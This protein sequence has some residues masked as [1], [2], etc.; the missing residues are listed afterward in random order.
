MA[1]PKGHT[2]SD[3]GEAGVIALFSPPGGAIGEKVVVPNGDDAAAFFT[4]PRYVS[5][6]TTDTLVEHVHFELGH[7]P[8]IRVGRKLM[9]V[10]LSDIAAMG[11]TPRYALL[12][13]C[14]PKSLP[15]VVAERIA[16]GVREVAKAHGVAVI[17]GNVTSSPGP[18]ML[19][20]TL[21]GRAEPEELVRRRGTQAGDAIFVTGRLGQARAGLRVLQTTGPLEKG[22]PWSKLVVALT[23]PKARVKT[24]R[25]LARGRFVHAMCDIS[26][27]FGVDLRSLLRL[28]QL[29]AR[30][31]ARALPISA[32]TRDYCAAQGLSP[33]RVALAG[34]EDYE[35][36]FTAH[37]RDTDAIVAECAST[38]TPVSRVGMVTAEP[39]LDVEMPSGELIPLIGGYDHF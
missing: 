17:G 37:P 8:E 32:A 39:L 13:V 10:N 9:S 19:S 31:D 28:E 21:V 20:A 18:M 33:E 24:G 36:L 27:G 12:S 22:H 35:L 15:V 11:A 7:G 38:G 23:D 16:I 29:G 25:A 34:G 14:F 30:I 4:E 6:V 2:L 1:D 5:V 26:D 3:I